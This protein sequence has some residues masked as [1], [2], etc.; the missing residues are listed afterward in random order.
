MFMDD[1]EE[2]AERGVGVLVRSFVVVIGLPAYCIG[3]ADSIIRRK[4]EDFRTPKT[5]K[6]AKVEIVYKKDIDI[7]LIENTET[8]FNFSETVVDLVID[9]DKKDKLMCVKLLDASQKLGIMRA[10]IEKKLEKVKKHIDNSSESPQ[11]E[12]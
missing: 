11:K 7:L 1:F 9:F 6:S 5:D 4:L 12:R 8:S 3:L 2:K 10:E